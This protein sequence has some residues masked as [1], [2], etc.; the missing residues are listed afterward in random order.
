MIKLEDAYFGV[1]KP[2]GR[3]ALEEDNLFGSMRVLRAVALYR[4]RRERLEA[5][6]PLFWCF[7]DT[8]GRFQYE[9]LVSPWSKDGEAMKVDVYKMHVE[10]NRDLLLGIVGN[11]SVASCEKWLKEHKR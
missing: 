10:P 7:G 9:W 1:M 6:D 3:G 8:S 4:A 2:N 11:I 5:L